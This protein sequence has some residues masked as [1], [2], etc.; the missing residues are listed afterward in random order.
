LN[1]RFYSFHNKLSAISQ[2]RTLGY[3]VPRHIRPFIEMIQPTTRFNHIRGQ[4]NFI[5]KVEK[6]T[7]ISEVDADCNV[8]I[9]PTCLR[10]LYGLGNRMM[11][12]N[13]RNK[14]GI[15]SYLEQYGQYDDLQSFLRSVA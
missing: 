13:P 15:S 2:I 4:K 1:T 10:E 14:L 3:A 7:P 11:V 9:T 6:E 12:P 5:L 8:T